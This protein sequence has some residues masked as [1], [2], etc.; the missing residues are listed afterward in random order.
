MEELG[1]RF[2]LLA[3]FHLKY[4]IDFVVMLCYNLTNNLFILS[5]FRDWFNRNRRKK[6]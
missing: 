2:R 3:Q 1:I 6:F 5:Y 4:L